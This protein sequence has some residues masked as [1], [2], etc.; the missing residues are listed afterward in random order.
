MAINEENFIVLAACTP[1]KTMI[2]LKQFCDDY[3]HIIVLMFADH[4][5]M[6][7][8]IYCANSLTHTVTQ[9]DTQNS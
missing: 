5:N 8:H 2:I 9:T 6:H 4:I 7:F 3:H 1:K